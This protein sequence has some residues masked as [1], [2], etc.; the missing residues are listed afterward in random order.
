MKNVYIKVQ[1]MNKWVAK[2]FPNQD[3]VSIDNLITV[4]E[5]LDGELDNLKEE[6]EEYKQNIEENYKQIP[7]SSQVNYNPEDFH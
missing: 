2:Y 4:I 6:F 7:Y 3:L 5:D 1:D